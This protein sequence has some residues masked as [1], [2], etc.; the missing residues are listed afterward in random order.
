MSDIAYVS[1]VRIERKVGP[2]CIAYLRGE[3]QAVT[4][5]VPEPSLSITR[6]L[7]QRST[8]LTRQPW[9]MSTA[10]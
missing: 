7:R 4:F 10:G 8:N 5:S 6:L 3:S 2:L 9:T 1:K